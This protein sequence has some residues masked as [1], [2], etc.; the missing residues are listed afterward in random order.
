MKR[1]I[2]ASSVGAEIEPVARGGIHPSMG[3]HTF[4]NA[5]PE[6]N[7]FGSVDGLGAGHAPGPAI[8]L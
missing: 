4:L 8:P 2:L 3:G 5:E 7:D 1:V 6:A